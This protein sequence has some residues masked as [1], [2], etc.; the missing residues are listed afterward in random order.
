MDGDTIDGVEE[1]Y[2]DKGSLQLAFSD[3][4]TTTLFR[5]LEQELVSLVQRYHVPP[6]DLDKLFQVCDDPLS[7][8][9]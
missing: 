2:E 6:G 7:S 8:G 4:E 9:Y 5:D 1:Y 3:S